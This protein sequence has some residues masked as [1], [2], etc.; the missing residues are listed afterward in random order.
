MEWAFLFMA[1]VFE[2][3]RAVC[4]KFSYG[5]TMTIPS[6][7]TVC[8]MIASVY[9]LALALRG[10]PLGTAYA[11]WTGIGTLGTVILGIRLFGESVSFIRII[12]IVL[13][14]AG[15]AGLKLTVSHS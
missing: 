8:L 11:A 13:T 14:A 5:F 15:T 7:C 9:F 2:A 4:L 10:L 12:C 1:A 6:V 3:G